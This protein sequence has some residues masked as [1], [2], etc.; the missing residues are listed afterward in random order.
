MAFRA[1]V[2]AW[3]LF[4]AS[5]VATPAFA[6]EREPPRIGAVVVPGIGGRLLALSVAVLHRPPA[7]QTDRPPT[8]STPPA[9]LPR[10]TI[11]TEWKIAF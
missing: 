10:P 4:L 7:P 6:E 8:W 3:S 1:L 2:C 11:A 9:G 5:A